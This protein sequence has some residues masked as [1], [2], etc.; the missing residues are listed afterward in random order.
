AGPNA[1]TFVYASSNPGNAWPW[2]PPNEQAALYLAAAVAK[3]MEVGATQLTFDLAD[4]KVT[5]RLAVLRHR[6]NMGL[7]FVGAGGLDLEGL[8]ARVQDYDRPEH[9]SFGTI[10]L[11]S[12]KC[13]PEL[14]ARIDQMLPYF[15][16]R[17]APHFQIIETPESFNVKTRESFSKAVADALEQL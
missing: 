8:R 14:R 5:N 7:L 6:N 11:V 13:T 17:A 3:G 15:A 1:V 4:G 12:N 2:S 10:V 9:S 16:R